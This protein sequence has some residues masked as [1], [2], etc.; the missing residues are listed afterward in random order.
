MKGMT[1]ARPSPTMSVFAAM[2][3]AASLAAAAGNGSEPEW[4]RVEVRT[5]TETG[6]AATTRIVEGMVQAEAADGGLLL[7]QADGRLDLFE[8]GSIASRASIPPPAGTETPR[9]LGRRI[10]G[11]LPTGFDLLITKHYVICF[12]TSRAYAQWAAALFER[13]HDGFMNFWTRAGLD[14]EPPEQPLIVVIFSDRRRYEEYAARDLGAATDRVVGYYNML[15]NRVTTFDLTG[16]DS[17]QG[18][19][20]LSGRPNL[21][22]LKRP[23]AA[24]LIATLIHE[25]THQLAFNGG[26][27]QRLAPVPLWVCEGVATYFE[28]PDL[29]SGR[30]WRAIGMVNRPRRDQFHTLPDRGWLEPLLRDDDAFRRADAATDAY[31]RGWALTAYLI[32]TK[33]PAFVAYLQGLAQKNP[34][35][36]DSPQQRIE[37]FTAAFGQPDA[38]LEQAVAAFVARMR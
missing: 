25:G 3:A 9:D 16:V 4:L 11:E 29:A 30:G 22:L 19:A 36:A 8:P 7:E 18:H 6:A 26:L 38:A 31:A 14:L 20:G 12:D 5:E 32:K 21:D 24:A 34:C 23:E 10:L 27:H 13:L 35:A 33:K 17:L 28:A 2:L 37:E 15:S 1:D